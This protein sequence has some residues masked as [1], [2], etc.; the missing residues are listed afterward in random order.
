[1]SDLPPPRPPVHHMRELPY[2][3]EPYS[4]KVGMYGYKTILYKKFKLYI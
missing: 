1:M 3:P 4:S 2:I